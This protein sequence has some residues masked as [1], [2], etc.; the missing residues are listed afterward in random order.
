MYS[1]YI[2]IPFCRK[3][4]NYC[5]FVSFHGQEETI[6][7]YLESVEKEMKKYSTNHIFTIFIGGGT[8]TLLS[9]ANFETLFKSIRTNFNCHR[10]SEVTVEANP[11]SLTLDKLK[12][13][14]TI[15][16]NRLS[17]GV[18]SFMDE[19]LFYLGRVH[20]FQDFLNAYDL[21]RRV[22]F[23]NINI[24]LIYGMPNQT[25]LHWQRTLQTAVSLAPEHISIYPLT[26]EP[27]TP[28]A[29][30]NI[31]VDEDEQAGMYEC[32]MD[33]L[34]SKGYRQ[35]EISN[36][37]KE[38]FKCRHNL[39]YWHN[40]EYIGIGVSAA[41]YIKGFRKK[42]TSNLEEYIRLIEVGASP[43]QEYENIDYNKKLSEEIILNLR[44]TSGFFLHK[45][46][47]QKYR[48]VI[49]VLIKKGLLQKDNQNIKLTRQG[50]LMANQVMKEFV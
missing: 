29:S 1:L 33:Y 7:V 34:A 9:C 38:G 22:D 50:L 13:L 31:A 10:L 8:P 4:C 17:I 24:D 35:Y 49:E 11:E 28:F 21:A 3:K 40:Y 41:S 2:H 25:L 23:A 46:I 39:T 45:H 37:S 36:W 18:Q 6:P 43:I 16:V 48:N 30:S 19:E 15:G 32:S 5:D 26:I 42:N 44:C 14:K 47:E 27:G 20:S 12:T